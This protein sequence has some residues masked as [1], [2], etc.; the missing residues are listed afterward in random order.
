MTTPLEELPSIGAPATLALTD[1]GYT[2]LAQLAGVARSDLA[3]LHGVGPRALALIEAELEQ[4]DLR[5]T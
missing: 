5:L 2:S 3:R 4:H 1:A